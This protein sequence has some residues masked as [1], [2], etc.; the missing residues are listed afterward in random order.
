MSLAQKIYNRGV[1]ALPII[2]P[3]V[4]DKSARLRFFITA[5]HSKE[6]IE[7]AVAVTAEESVR[8]G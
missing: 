7:H 8:L 6:Q 2:P 1:Y 4:P 3:G 5:E